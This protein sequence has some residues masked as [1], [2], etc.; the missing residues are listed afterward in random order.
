MAT[1]KFRTK[2]MPVEYPEGGH[3]YTLIRVPQLTRSHCDMAAF[4]RHRRY[5]SFA[6]SDLFPG[7]LARIRKRVAPHGWFKVEDPPAGVTV[8][9]SGI[10]AVVT[11][12]ID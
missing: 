7:I 5:G 6:N 11:I 3:A 9:A 12:E 1:I 2:P 10:L 8:D 4:R